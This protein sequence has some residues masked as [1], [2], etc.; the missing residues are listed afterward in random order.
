[1]IKKIYDKHNLLISKL[2]R[3]VINVFKLSSWIQEARYVNVC[4]WDIILWTAY[5]YLY[6]YD[7]N[8]NRKTFGPLFTKA[9][10]GGL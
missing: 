7:K 5:I 6:R 3:S 2:K 1:M 9:G 8:L 10:K 4:V